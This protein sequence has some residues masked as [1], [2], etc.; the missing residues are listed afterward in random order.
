MKILSG[1]S[2][3][4]GVIKPS[5]KIIIWLVI[6][7]CI[8]LISACGT[9]SQPRTNIANFVL[10]QADVGSQFTMLIDS[11][12]GPTQ[13]SPFE[14]P[15]QH[16]FVGGHFRYFMT[17]AALDPTGK[18]QITNWEEAH[19]FPI[20]SPYITIMGPFVSTHTGVFVINSQVLRYSNADSA[21]A[22]YHCCKAVGNQ[23]NFT[24]YQTPN[25]KI[26]DE[27]Q[28]FSGIERYVAAPNPQDCMQL[29]AIHWRRG[30]FVSFLSVLGAHD[31]QL[32][33]AM[34]L[35]QIV[36]QRITQE[37]A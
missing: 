30:D 21:A 31:I 10:S 20:T 1:R 29:Y 34:R 33:D 32:S 9:S 15:Y 36:D 25:V 22:D 8:C 7:L 17:N 13:R 35:A 24:D 16:D 23:N 26:G 3:K 6:L 18:A 5:L 27:S 11:I 19:N 4:N 14:L 37:M 28:A 2:G 12:A